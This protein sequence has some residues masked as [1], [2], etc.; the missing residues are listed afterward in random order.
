MTIPFSSLLISEDSTRH[1]NLWSYDITF[2]F[3]CIRAPGAS[4]WRK[5]NTHLSVAMYTYKI[6]VSTTR[7]CY[8]WGQ[9]GHRSVLLI[10]PQWN[11]KILNGTIKTVEISRCSALWFLHGLPF[12]LLDGGGWSCA[13]CLGGWIWQNRVLSS[14]GVPKAQAFGQWLPLGWKGSTGW[15]TGGW[16][17]ATGI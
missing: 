1:D 14:L 9:N 6:L 8:F 13:R 5:Q 7:N 3:P 17:N 16:G 11:N 12:Y 15:H 10:W 2:F 4:L